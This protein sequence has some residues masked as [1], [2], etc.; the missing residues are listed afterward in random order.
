MLSRGRRN[1]ARD[2]HLGHGSSTL[3]CMSSDSRLTCSVIATDPWSKARALDLT[4]LHGR[5]ETPIFMPVATQAALRCVDLP[6]ADGLDFQ[7]LLANTYHLLLRPGPE[8][9]AHHGGIH[10]FMNWQRGVLTDSGG[11]QIFS[12]SK[13]LALSEEGATFRSYVDG[14]RI[15]LTPEK[16]IEMQRVIGSDIMMVLD[17]CITSTCTESEARAALELTTRWAKRS[18]VARGDSRQALF[19]IV[20]GACFPQL[21]KESAEQITSIPFDGFALGGLAVGESKAEREDTTE[22]AAPLLP[23]DKP[24]YL[25]GVG[26]PIDL[27]EAVRRGMDMFDCILPTSL[28]NQGVVFTSRGRLDLRRGVYRSDARPLDPECSCSTC[29]R[30][31]RSYLQHL[32]RSSEFVAGQ[33]LS[34]HNLTFYRKLMRGMRESIIAGTFREFYHSQVEALS[35]DD[36]DNPPKPPPVST[37]IDRLVLGNYEIVVRENKMGAIR[38]RASA[39][40]MHVSEDPRTE[41]HTLYVEGSRL[42]DRVSEGTEPLVIWDV[43]LGAAT[44]SMVGLL[45]LEEREAIERPIK[46]VSFENDLDSLRLAL[47]HPWYFAHLRH[48]AP[49]QLLKDGRWQSSKHPL[50]WEL[51][52]G[53]F[54]DRCDEADAPDIIWFDP[55]SSKVDSPMWTMPV[56][57]KVLSLTR[58]KATS[59]HTYSS[60]TA[61]RASLLHAG[62]FVGRGVGTGMKRETTKAYTVEAVRRGLATDLL[63]TSWLGRWERSDSQVPVGAD[64]EP[65]KMVVRG[66]PQFGGCR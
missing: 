15:H 38:H 27:L 14:R 5:V 23:A 8:V 36:L 45:A 13:Q 20:Q 3:P 49:H 31:T 61:I 41:S 11:F 28:A 64:P 22:F 60:S 29:T 16:S 44:N 9:M 2:F 39:E 54:M 65:F 6:I 34:I 17:Q 63:D 12:L 43:G 56:L 21:R 25:M 57:A 59:L 46:I 10:R 48:G 1:S 62:W 50:T 66:H 53:D 33:L 4:T 37:K 32:V 40:V 19:G 51:Q 35:S 24:R 55:F 58:G 47:Q 7:V 18:F 42:F 52:H 30:Y 26:T